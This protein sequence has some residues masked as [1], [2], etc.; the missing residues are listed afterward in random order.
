LDQAKG[1]H[2]V[3]DHH[4]LRLRADAR[5][6]V[7]RPFH[8][9]WQANGAEPSRARRLVQRVS[10]LSHD[11]VSEELERVYGD[12]AGRHIQVQRVFQRRY[13]QMAEQ[14]AAE[15]PPAFFEKLTPRRRQL[16]G[17]FF[18]HEY[19]Y[20]AAALMNPTV[21][22]HPDQG[23]L[24]ARSVRFIMPVRTVG[25]GHIS[26]ISFFE[27]E[28]DEHRNVAIKDAPLIATAADV[29]R[30]KS[31]SAPFD[32]DRPLAVYRQQDCDLSRTVIFPMTSSQRN[33]VEDLRLTP[34]VHKSGRREWIGTYTAYDGQS[35]RSEILSTSDFRR[36]DLIPMTGTASRNKGMALF[37]RKINGSYAM[38]G[39]QDGE[40]LFLL[41]SE[42]LTNWDE[43]EL[44]LRP[45]HAW[46]F[47][48]MGNCGPPIEIDEGWL[49][50][51]HGVGAMRRYSIG[52]ILLDKADPSRVLGR[53][54][55]PVL[56]PLD[57][58][59]DGYVP[60]VVY[61]CGAMKVGKDIFMPYGIA[62]S[63]IGFAFIDIAELLAA[64][65]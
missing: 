30:Q 42:V 39:R 63:S 49:L 40:N 59:R 7:V 54:S 35:I 33:G 27:G 43:G 41:K 36:F 8:L 61:T 15:F 26:T 25:E 23:I 34:F 16:L 6:V 65:N 57:E 55:R 12:F 10:D 52:A 48:Q 31:K 13:E 47:I 24:N 1:A 28:V 18:C 17:A 14:L 11:E 50:L 9:A 20:A 64:M 45:E 19:S 2:I 37:P 22:A 51:T 56:E 53:T 60:N 38:I 5:R 4:P 44:L 29:S 46:E 62:D 21:V 58:E 3:V 32:P